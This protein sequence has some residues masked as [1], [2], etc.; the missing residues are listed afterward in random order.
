MKAVFLG[1]LQTLLFK[2]RRKSLV[3]FISLVAVF[4]FRSACWK[5]VKW[6]YQVQHILTADE[7]GLTKCPACLGINTSLCNSILNGDITV[8][9]NGFWTN[10]YTK[11]VMYGRWKGM[12]VVVKY[13]ASTSEIAEFESHICRSA[14]VEPSCD[15][16]SNAWRSFLANETSVKKYVINA[17][18]T[19][20]P[21]HMH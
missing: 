3:L 9:I 10:E 13:L 6:L 8:K 15:L 1:F 17:K 7:I 21:A 14:G 4:V 20:L 16:K 12:D 11:G 19:F 2:R 5:T 18:S